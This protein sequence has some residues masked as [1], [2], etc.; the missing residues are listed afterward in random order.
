V[1]IF[2]LGIK[3]A[4]GLV[5]ST[6]NT[7]NAFSN[8]GTNV[9][10]INIL[11]KNGGFDFL[12]PAFPLSDSVLRYSLDALSEIYSSSELHNLEFHVEN[13][14]FLK[15]VYN[16][17]HAKALQDINANLT[18]ND[19]II[20]SHP[21]AMV[22]FAKANKKTKAKTLIQV[23]GNY[24]EEV[25]NLAL[26]RDY[27]DYVDYIQTVS[28][29]MRDD[30]IELLGVNQDKVVCIYNITH[31]IALS[32]NKEKLLKR[33]SIIGSIQK[34]KNQLDAVRMLSLIQDRNV[35]LQIYGNALK[36]EYLDL[37]NFH[38]NNYGLADRVIFKGLSSEKD[39][40]ENT[41]V[42]IMTSE[43][44][45]FGYIFLEAALY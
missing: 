43:H 38:I 33:I 2:A 45:G 44:E 9:S 27:V 26:L 12:D 15:A 23:H 17:A 16:G 1:Y 6:I 42:A 24:I 36:K 8:S 40:Y 22:L 11:G 34:R 29:Y 4:N 31:P 14:Q 3:A 10:I 25:D 20:F 32:K 37:L 28:K 39:I 7:A 35:I 41:D 30:L 13:Q 21:L 18:E 19:L 5:K